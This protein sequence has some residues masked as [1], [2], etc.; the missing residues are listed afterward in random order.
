MACKKCKSESTTCTCIN[1]G[2]TPTDAECVIYNSDGSPSNLNCIADI[3]PGTSVK[4]ILETWDNY[5]CG[6]TQV[7]I[8]SCVKEKLGISPTVDNLTHGVLL[9]S[10]QNWIC[11][12]QDVNVKV[13]PADTK[14]GYLNSKIVTGDCIDT[15][16]VIENGEQKLK[17]SL[18][19]PCISAKIPLC[20]DIKT[21]ECLT[22]DFSGSPCQP[23]PL[24][25]VVVRSGLTL[26]GSNCN[27]MLQWYNSNDEMISTGTNITVEPL[28]TYYAR[29][30][31][32]CGQSE[33]SYQ[34]S[35]PPVNTFT[36]IRSAVFTRICGTN[37]CGVPCLGSSTTFSKTY[38]STISQEAANSLAENDLS[39]A[40]DGQA[41]VNMMGTC[42]CPDC[43]CDFPVYNSNVVINNATCS[44][45]TV[46]ANGQITI[47]GISKADKF[48]YSLG[49]GDYNGV[50]YSS[51]ISL[52]NFSQGNIETTP[53]SI[54]LKALSIE[55]RVVFRIF[56][57]NA[58]CY[59][60][61]VVLLTPPDCSKPQVDIENITIACDIEETIC[62]KWT[63][64]AGA[65]GA[66]VWY[67]SCNSNA[68]DFNDIAANQT[69]E[70][71]S[72]SIPQA[73]GGVVTQNGVC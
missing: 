27:G 60:D 14:T 51:A 40:I 36:K 16:V 61:V 50:S 18:N 47:A 20:L 45:S 4:A 53:T 62:K 31:T 28:K 64:V 24:T 8:L 72:P 1:N 65:T 71:C 29:C 68:Y 58:S 63:I 22:V 25:P 13:T 9:T 30:V 57:G 41:Y 48:G 15:S 54:K 67:Q 23:Q 66:K 46:N 44:G 7:N 42:T 59:K 10:I 21:N 11:N 6:M 19:F 3:T 12:Y 37:E 32:G 39:F 56:N 52:N 2:C 5:F 35:T 49:A 73:N 38:T 17:I 55:T 34:V 69:V 43:N 33:K 26:V 70:R